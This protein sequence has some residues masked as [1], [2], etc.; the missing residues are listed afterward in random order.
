MLM[1]ATPIIISQESIEIQAKKKG[2]LLGRLFVR[3]PLFE[4]NLEYRK[5]FSINLEHTVV[6][7]KFPFG[8]HEISGSI[9]IIVDAMFDKCGVK[10]ISESLILEDIE[11]IEFQNGKHDMTDNQAIDCAQKYARRIIFRICKNLP[12]FTTNHVSYFYRPFWIAYYG[13]PNATKNPR[14]LPY[15]ADGKS[16]AR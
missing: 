10:E 15:E 11:G 12:T 3:E 14:Y 2:G 7:R 9:N 16:F 5:F 6:A 1:K 4:V 8:K 13:N